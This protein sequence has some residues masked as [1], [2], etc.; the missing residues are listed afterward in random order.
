MNAIGA[1]HGSRLG[2][3][4]SRAV[5]PVLGALLFIVVVVALVAV[6]IL[7]PVYFI[8]AILIFLG[9]GIAIGYRSGWG[10]L[11]GIVLAVAGIALVVLATVAVI[12]VVL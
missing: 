5:H 8:G 11:G 3:M 2:R 12:V 9:V 7:V 4:G 1:D 6:F 10:L